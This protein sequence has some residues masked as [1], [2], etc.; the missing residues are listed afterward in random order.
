MLL[1]TE[2]NAMPGQ[3]SGPEEDRL[4]RYASIPSEASKLADLEHT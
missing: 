2:D 3:S 4:L 1:L